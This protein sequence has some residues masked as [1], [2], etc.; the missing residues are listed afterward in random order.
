MQCMICLLLNP[1]DVCCAKNRRKF[2]IDSIYNTCYIILDLAVLHNYMRMVI[3][4]YIYVL[5]LLNCL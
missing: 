2:I 3:L 5:L 1:I 4:Y